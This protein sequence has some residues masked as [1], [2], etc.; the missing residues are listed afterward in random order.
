[1]K[2]ALKSG[3]RPLL[4]VG[5]SAEQRDAGASAAAVAE[6]VKQGFAGLSPADM[7]RCLVAYEPV[8]AIGE[9]GV[10]AKPDQIRAVLLAIRQAIAERTPARTPVLYGGSVTVDNVGELAAEPTIDGLFI[11]RAAWEPK[12]F[13]AMIDSAIEARG[14]LRADHDFGARAAGMKGRRRRRRAKR[15]R[16]A[17]KRAGR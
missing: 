3:L 16:P 1:M 17:R 4:C 7:G 6:Q 10:A 9:G 14:A 11:G 15:Y 13:A 5:D 8:W 12:R 2:S